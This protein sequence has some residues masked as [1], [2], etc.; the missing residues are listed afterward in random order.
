LDACTASA[1]HDGNTPFT[2]WTSGSST[3]GSFERNPGGTYTTE[4][5]VLSDRGAGGARSRRLFLPQPDGT[6]AR[7]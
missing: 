2:G 6:Q 4:S 7:R 3:S 1:T 5:F